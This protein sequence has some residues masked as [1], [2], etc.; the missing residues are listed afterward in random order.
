MFSLRDSGGVSLAFI[1][2]VLPHLPCALRILKSCNHCVL[3]YFYNII[4]IGVKVLWEMKDHFNPSSRTALWDRYKSSGQRVKRKIKKNP[5]VNP[6]IWNLPVTFTPPRSGVTNGVRIPALNG[7]RG[8]CVLYAWN[9]VFS[10]I[11]GWHWWC[12][13]ICFNLIGSFISQTCMDRQLIRRGQP[14]LCM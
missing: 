2:G 12:P 11:S 3:C 4:L 8:I 5:N 6:Q 13:L 9:S 10:L 14:W 7:A 1:C